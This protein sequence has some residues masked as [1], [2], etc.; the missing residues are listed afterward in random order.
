MT[1]KTGLI[2]FFIANQLNLTCFFFTPIKHFLQLGS[3]ETFS[4]DDFYK[5]LV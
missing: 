1:L 2:F 3:K 4:Q 5:G